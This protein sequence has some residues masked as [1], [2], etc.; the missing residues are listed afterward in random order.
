[1]FATGPSG[2]DRS[3]RCTHRR[4][5]VCALSSPSVCAHTLYQMFQ[6][7]IGAM[8]TFAR[9]LLTAARI[10]EDGV[11]PGMV[12]LC[13]G[14]RCFFLTSAY[15]QVR[16][17]YENWHGGLGAKIDQGASSFAEVNAFISWLF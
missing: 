11:L 16:R 15:I 9:G 8:D 14:L 17:R 4:G 5:S 3:A 6:G 2:I 12:Q 13:H 7:H 1:M 10:V